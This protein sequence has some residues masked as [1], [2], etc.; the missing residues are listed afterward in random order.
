MEDQVFQYYVPQ[1]LR[2]NEFINEVKIHFMERGSEDYVTIT[3]YDGPDEI[4]AQVEPA[5]FQAATQI[6]EL[7][8]FRQFLGWAKAAEGEVAYRDQATIDKTN[9]PT[10]VDS[11]AV[12]YAKWGNCSPI[13]LPT[14]LK[15]G[16]ALERWEFQDGVEAGK[17][18]DPFAPTG[19]TYLYA[20]WTARQFSVTFNPNGGQ[21]PTGYDPVWHVTY[22]QQYGNH[23]GVSG[24]QFPIPSNDEWGFKGWYTKERGGDLVT[25]ESNVAISEDHTLY[26]HWRNGTMT[27]TFN[28]TDGE[29]PPGTEQTKTCEVD[30]P[31]GE[32]PTPICAGYVSIGW[33]TSREAR[34]EDEID[35]NTIAP[36]DDLTVYASWLPINYSVRFDANGGS[37][38]MEDQIFTYGIGVRLQANQFTRPGSVFLGW[39]YFP[40]GDVMF[41]DE[42]IALNL[43][44]VPDEM[45][46]LYAIWQ[47][48]PI[49]VNFNTSWDQF[50][51]TFDAAGGE[52]GWSKKLDAG[53]EITPP[54]VT[55]LN[56]TFN[57]WSPTPP[58][59][60]PENDVTCVAQW[61]EFPMTATV[62]TN[63]KKATCS[64][65]KPSNAR[66]QYS[67]TSKTSG[68][69]DGTQFTLSFTSGANQKKTGWFKLSCEGLTDAIY[70][71]VITQ[72]MV[73]TW[74]DWSAWTGPGSGKDVAQYLTILKN[75]YGE[76]NYE[77]Q[78]WGS[79]NSLWVRERH[80][81]GTVE[82]YSSKITK[83]Q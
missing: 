11:V 75:K 43:V 21:L 57:G 47:T 44:N 51:M 19:E 82:T 12:L 31:F 49:T 63:K 27:L 8:S 48:D 20:S 61:T 4:D 32:L 3:M 9:M 50:G 67:K 36:E 58:T 17:P 14:A 53:D 25:A 70:K 34:P 54:E 1:R 81:T 80:V 69:Q 72:T 13:A 41:Q 10:I 62:T 33:F 64:N 73:E 22:G 26:A 7:V 55:W 76:G 23:D 37:G 42:A 83:V 40:Q 28:P 46:I 52:G 18:N 6:S 79:G 59:T 29:L 74:S 65:V 5:P 66:V 38:T 45:V 39:S 35:E 78:G 77:T 60:M 30:E 15:A 16:Y 68:Y 24:D 56:H 2:E 71:V